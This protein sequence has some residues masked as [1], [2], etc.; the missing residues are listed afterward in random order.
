MDAGQEGR[1]AAGRAA[2]TRLPPMV[3]LL[4]GCVVAAGAI[5]AHRALRCGD[6]GP[7]GS[8]RRV[9]CLL[10]RA[11]C[12]ESAGRHRAAVRCL[13]DLVTLDPDVANGHLN[14]GNLHRRRGETAL[15]EAAYRRVIDLGGDLHEAHLQLGM[16]ALEAGRLRE[17]RAE[18]ERS[19]LHDDHDCGVVHAEYG[20]ALLRSGD[21]SG[22]VAELEIARARTP[23]YLPSYMTLGAIHEEAGELAAAARVYAE[24][25]KR[26]ER[27]LG[28]LRLLGRWVRVQSRRLRAALSGDMG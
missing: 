12:L 6:C 20:R 14:L 17:A 15:A 9:D 22:A 26:G 2:G 18:L 21:R 8:E 3:W 1:T 4:A 7:V 11:D 25:L 19:I 24:G 23:H 27:R 5:L 28:A 10:Q 16:M 13:E